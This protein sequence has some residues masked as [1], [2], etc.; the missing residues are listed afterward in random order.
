[1]PTAILA[2]PAAFDVL[3][4]AFPAALATLV[5]QAAVQSITRASTPSPLPAAT[6]VGQG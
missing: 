4:A 2:P 3:A 6:T 1:M 5:K